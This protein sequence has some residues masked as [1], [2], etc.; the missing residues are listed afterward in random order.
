MIAK[1][2][3]VLEDP[4]TE[5]LMEA[6]KFLIDDVYT[7]IFGLEDFGLED[8]FC[9]AQEL[10]ESWSNTQ[11][12]DILLTLFALLF[13]I[14]RTILMTEIFEEGNTTTFDEG[15]DDYSESSN[16]QHKIINLRMKAIFQ[17]LYY[18]VVHCRKNTPFA[19]LKCPCNL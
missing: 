2:Y 14:N 1:K 17:I 8:K 15:E 18:Q 10:R 13:N 6:G 19:H 9:N 3:I 16:D 4:Q 11:I 12:P 7:R 5:K